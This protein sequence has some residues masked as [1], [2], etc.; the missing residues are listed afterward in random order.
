LPRLPLS[1]NAAIARAAQEHRA[2]LL[3]SGSVEKLTKALCAAMVAALNFC[4]PSLVAH[5]KRARD[6]GADAQMLNDIWNYARSER[7]TGA[8]KAAL[9]AAVALT[10]EPRGLPDTVWNGLRAHFDDAQIVELLC[11]I[12]V[13]NYLDRVDNALQS[14]IPR[15]D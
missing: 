6:L 8:Q 4:N 14:D 1:A 15:G 13:G 10:R 7:Y 2:F 3:E 11:V 5:R 9:A 12:G